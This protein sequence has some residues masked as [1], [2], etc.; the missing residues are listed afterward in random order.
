MSAKD[1]SKIL[2]SACLLGERV[3]YDGAH[4]QISNDFLDRLVAD[5]RVVAL[6]PEL[7]GGLSIPRLPAEITGTRVFDSEGQDIT[8]AYDKG[9]RKAL[10]LAKMNGCSFALLKDGSPSC[11]VFE[12]YDGSF[13]GRKTIGQGMTAKLL[14]QN[15]IKVFH[16]HQIIELETALMDIDRRSA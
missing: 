10:D 8:T 1:Q 7:A 4:K 12:V 14:S 13:S 3:R 6:C 15:G 11:G 2:V 9:A 5:N 16:E